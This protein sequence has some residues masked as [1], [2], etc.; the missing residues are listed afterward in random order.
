[1]TTE[2]K[3]L[4]RRG[5]YRLGQLRTRGIRAEQPPPPFR[6]SFAP[7]HRRGAAS[8]WLLALAG[9]VVLIAVAAALG[10]WFM[11]FAAGLAAGLANRVAGFRAKVAVPAV[12]L[13][14]AAGWGFPLLWQATRDHQPYGAVARETAALGG[15]PAYAATGMA[16]TLL[17]AVVQAVVGYWLGRALTP[18]PSRDG[19][20]LRPL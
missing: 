1:M 17:V 20:P 14:A 18:F 16:V 12:V 10:W 11:P 19:A 2:F 15:L 7:S 5:S 3:R 4:G 13:M 9:G 6:M 8:G